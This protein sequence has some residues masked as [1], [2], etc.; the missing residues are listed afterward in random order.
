MEAHA[1]TARINNDVKFPFLCLLI[2]GGHS[3]LAFVKDVRTF[4]LLGTSLDDAPGEAF[5]KIARR[6]KMRNLK[7][8][9]NKSGGQSMEEAARMCTELTGKYQFPLMLSRYKDCQ[10]SFAGLKNVAKRYI[11]LEEKLL[12]L[13]VDEVIPDYPEFC[14]GFISATTRHICHRTQRAIEFCERE[15][16]FE[17]TEI[18]TLV[19]SGGVAC[20][21][22]IFEALSQL[23][24]QMNVKA[25]RPSKQLCTDNGIMIA[26]NGIE[27][28]RADRECELIY[29]IDKIAVHAKC[30]LGENLIDHVKEKGMNCKWIKIP[31]LKDIYSYSR[32]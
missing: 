21:D 3:L 7:E 6:L 2:S 9:E 17:N 13:D 12:K 5:D 18:K 24:E 32:N 19:V 16:M 31:L 26:W 8:F 22:F 25:I 10:F 14:K 4:Q 27:R 29:D 30:E 11:M 23:C 15:K 20:N 28:F 1:L